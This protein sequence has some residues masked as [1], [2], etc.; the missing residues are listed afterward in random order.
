MVAYRKDDFQELV[1]SPNETLDVEYKEWLD[2]IGDTEARADV[3]RH[4]AALANHGGGVLVFGFK[5]DMRY[6]GSNPYPK[7]IVGHDLVSSIVK[8][9]LEPTFQC[10]VRTIKSRAGNE[11]PVI[12][13]PP[14]GAVPICAKAGGPQVNGRSKGITQGIYYA[15]KAGPESAPITNSADWTSIIRRCAMHER[16][17]ILGAIDAALRAPELAA[18][19][20][21]DALKVWHDAARPLY[22]KDVGARD[23]PPFYSTAF[24]QLSYAIERADG[25]V[26]NVDRLLGTLREVNNEVRDLVSTGWSMFHPFAGTGAPYFNTDEKSGLGESDFL[27][28]THLR[29]PDPS[30]LAAEMW[31]VS[32]D[33]KCTI[34]RSYLEDDIM[35]TPQTQLAQG[36]WFSPQMMVCSLAELVRHARGIGERFGE[37]SAV[38]FRCE[39]SG[40]NKRVLYDPVGR[41]SGRDPAKQDRRVSSGTYPFSSLP[42][43]LEDIVAELA[44]P[45][46]RIFIS[47]FVI[48]P[49]WVRGQRKRWRL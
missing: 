2:L 17:S 34:I 35:F 6:A 44:Q 43:R 42:N 27:E 19:S 4:I 10:D 5:D 8:K 11:H 33:G 38:H 36:T 23:L 45:V 16:T 24:Y 25:Q 18:D 14:H 20:V 30:F 48:T 49:E 21:A 47:D 7:V 15:R 37:P 46:M 13:V 22:V 31:R 9:Y 39:W 41:W 1:D 28:C 12:V 3:A 26:L 40:L 29:N 32:P